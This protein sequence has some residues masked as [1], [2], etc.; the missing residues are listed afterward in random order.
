[1]NPGHHSMLSS[2]LLEQQILQ[3]PS[4]PICLAM[5]LPSP[6]TVSRIHT[7]IPTSKPMWMLRSCHFPRNRFQLSGQSDQLPST[8]PIHH[9]AII[10]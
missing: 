4:P 8:V 5:R 10:Q 1:M 7:S 2:S 3:F 9:S 6:R